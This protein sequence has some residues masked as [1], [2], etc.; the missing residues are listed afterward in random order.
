M[1]PMDGIIVK[2]ACRRRMRRPR[3]I[4]SVTVVLCDDCVVRVLRASSN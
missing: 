4:L 1:A 3:W 2:S